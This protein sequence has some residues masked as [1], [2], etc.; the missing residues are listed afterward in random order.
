VRFVT[1][2]LL[3]VTGF[4]RL[5]VGINPAGLV[6]PMES[7]TDHV[8]FSERVWTAVL[9][10]VPYVDNQFSAERA[11]D[12]RGISGASKTVRIDEDFDAPIQTP[13]SGRADA[14]PVPEAEIIGLGG[15]EEAFEHAAAIHLDGSFP[16]RDFPS[17]EGARGRGPAIFVL[18]AR[19]IRSREQAQAIM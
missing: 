4:R 6:A 13:D 14:N 19:E 3:G 17:G 12:A 11:T 8:A 15:N 5:K 9:K 7:R 18:L 1:G 16:D 2:N 10:K